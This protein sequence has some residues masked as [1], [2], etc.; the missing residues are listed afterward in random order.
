MTHS[1]RPINPVISHPQHLTS[2]E[3]IMR[4]KDER[5]S[6]IQSLTIYIKSNSSRLGVS[7]NG[8]YN[9]KLCMIPAYKINKL[10]IQ[11]VS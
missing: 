1:L 4:I 10:F 11:L 7:G 3:D 2:C 5:E 9:L 8:P 6:F